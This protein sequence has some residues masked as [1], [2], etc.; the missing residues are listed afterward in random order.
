[1]ISVAWSSLCTYY[2]LPLVSHLIPSVQNPLLPTPH[3][4]K[5]IPELAGWPWTIPFIETTTTT[6]T[7]WTQIPRH[8]PLQYYSDSWPR[9]EPQP[10]A[11]I[12]QWR[13]TSQETRQVPQV[14]P[15]K[16]RSRVE[17][18]CCG[19]WAAVIRRA[20]HRQDPVAAPQR[21]QLRW[22]ERTCEIQR[23]CW[24]VPTTIA[25]MD[26]RLQQQLWAVSRGT[27]D[28]SMN[29]RTV[30]QLRRSSGDTPRRQWRCSRSKR[31]RCTRPRWFWRRSRSLQRRRRST[32][33]RTQDRND[34]RLDLSSK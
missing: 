3:P 5:N 22:L 2:N 9:S 17:V 12:Q 27:S 26:R 21:P 24:T 30:L 7:I 23:I 8:R 11:R 28:R 20:H 4:Q 31:I 16:V 34:R 6:N 1:M 25:T 33:K 19:L 29:E 32:R 10:K 13:Q 18:D 14:G 15:Q